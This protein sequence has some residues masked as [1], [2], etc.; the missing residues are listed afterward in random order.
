MG[1][2]TG[3]IKNT[4]LFVNNTKKEAADT[5][6]MISDT[7]KKRGIETEVFLFEG[8]IEQ[9]FERLKHPNENW[10]IAFSIGGDGTVLYTARCLAPLGVPI[11]PVNHG[12]FG[13]IAGEDREN[14]LSVFEKWEKGDISASKRC[15]LEVCVK[16]G[17]GIVY[18]KLCLNDAVISASE[19]VKLIR[20]NIG[21]DSE[22]GE[23]DLGMCRSDGLIVSTPTGST[24]YNLSAGGPVLDPEMEAIAL[25]PICPFALSS[26]PIVLPLQKTVV[27]TVAQEQRCGVILTVD[28]QDRFN[29]EC[30]DKVYIKQA[31]HSAMLIY[32]DNNSYYTALAQRLGLNN[33]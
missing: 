31:L 28:G 9:A 16:R 29:L 10:D 26:R 21:F 5:A 17:S 4:I 32:A 2:L 25:V 8:K 22:K 18:K 23:I 20:L 3:K 13:F 12:S 1:N 15:M 6:V 24:A 7:L 19:I 11:L 14:W 30:N 27:I 33:A